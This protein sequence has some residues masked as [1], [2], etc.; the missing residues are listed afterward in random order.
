MEAR[1]CRRRPQ[2]I[3]LQALLPRL[4]A[5]ARAMELLLPPQGLRAARVRKQRARV[6]AR[7]LNAGAPLRLIRRRKR[8]RPRSPRSLQLRMKGDKN[9]R[10]RDL[11]AEPDFSP[12][13][14]CKLAEDD[15][16]NEG[17]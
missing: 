14:R 4:Q 8:R 16:S 5:A 17:R 10:N 2:P 7:A 3:L 15:T 9:W 1:N 12:F 6:V 13:V 11:V